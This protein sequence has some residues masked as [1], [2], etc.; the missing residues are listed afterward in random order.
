MNYYEAYCGF[1]EKNSSF[2]SSQL[3]SY[4]QTF[5]MCSLGGVDRD[6]N[7]IAYGNHL[8]ILEKATLA[9]EILLGYV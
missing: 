2:L 4:I 5:G 3:F 6:R 9:L 7:V 1:Q 8:K